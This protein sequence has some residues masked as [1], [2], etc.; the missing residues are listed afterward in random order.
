LT[1][2]GAVIPLVKVNGV[3][4]QSFYFILNILFQAVHHR[5]Y[6]YDAEDADG[7]AEKGK[8]SAEFIFPQLLQRHFKTAANDFYGPADH[9]VKL[10]EDRE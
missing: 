5:Q 1:P 6:A 8:K 2:T 4:A 7:D 9:A 3:G 10:P